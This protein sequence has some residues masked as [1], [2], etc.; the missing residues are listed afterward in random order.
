MYLPALILTIES[1]LDKS[2]IFPFLLFFVQKLWGGWSYLR[3]FLAHIIF[4]IVKKILC[5]VADLRHSAGYRPDFE[6]LCCQADFNLFIHESPQA[7]M[8]LKRL[9]RKRRNAYDRYK[10]R[11]FL[12]LTRGSFL[13]LALILSLFS[14]IRLVD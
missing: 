3:N 5:F 1:K 12:S 8:Q 13:R 10:N 6:L 9:R 2:G 4:L 7:P 11:P 14:S